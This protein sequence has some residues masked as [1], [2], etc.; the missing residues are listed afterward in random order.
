MGVLVGVLLSEGLVRLS[1]PQPLVQV[2]PDIWMPVEGFGYQ[3]APHVDTIINTGERDV[4]LLT[5]ARGNRIGP[6][7]P[8]R[9][10]RK[11]LAVGDSFVE[12]LSVAYPDLVTTRLAE[13]MDRRRSRPRSTAGRTREHAVVTAGVSGWDPSHYYRKTLAE[14]AVEDYE[15]VLL[16]VFTD[17]DVVTHSGTRH[18]PRPNEGKSPFACRRA[19]T[20][21]SLSTD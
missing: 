9:G 8:P 18:P 19:S 10:R 7:G 4:R 3:M 14:L 6:Q 15:L 20:T 2:R 17:N 21:G 12:G 16:F 13:L 1:A 11:I 5:D